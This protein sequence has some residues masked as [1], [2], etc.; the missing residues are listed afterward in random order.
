MAAHL[1]LDWKYRDLQVVRLENDELRV[2]VLPELGGK[3][4]SLVHRPS[5]RE[6]LWHNPHVPPQRQR[7]GGCFDDAWSGGWDELLPTDVP[8]P[9]AYGDT[10]PD[11]GEVWSQPC[12]W[13]VLEAGDERV[14]V[15]LVSRGRVWPSR[16]EK[17]LTVPGRGGVCQLRYRYTNQAN[18]PLD[19]LWNIHPALR[20]SAGT[21]L[22]TPARRVLSDPWSTDR[23][24]PWSE[25]EWP[26]TV[27]RHGRAV[28]LSRVPLPGQLAE[29]LYLSG[30]TEGWWAATDPEAKVGL[31][32]VF[33]AD[34]FPYVWLFASYGGWRGLY[35]AILEAS[36]GCPKDLAVARASGRCGRLEAGATLEVEVQAVVYSGCASVRQIRPDGSVVPEA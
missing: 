24:D 10:L 33:P 18:V 35:V 23:F 9:I 22:Q 11:H 25:H 20:I 16:F 26:E 6:L 36:T 4:W 29:H 5:G 2:D 12:Q 8:T 28:D 31:G 14:S 13:Q 3:I 34:V 7:F 27:D 15:C 17:T 30:L 21:R 19:F 1:D 32:L